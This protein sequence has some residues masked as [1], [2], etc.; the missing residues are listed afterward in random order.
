MTITKVYLAWVNERSLRHFIYTLY[1]KLI[2]V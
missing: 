1:I 2:T